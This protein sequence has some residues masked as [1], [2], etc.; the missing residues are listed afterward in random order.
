MI[1]GLTTGA[2][3]VT[4]Q[5]VVVDGGGKIEGII[6]QSDIIKGLEGK[7]VESLK[8]IIRES[9]EYYDK[10]KHEYS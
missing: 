10:R 3:F 1:V 8:E 5:I 2:A 9:L 6:T 4:G 7:Y